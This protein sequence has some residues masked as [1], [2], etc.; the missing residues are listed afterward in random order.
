MAKEIRVIRFDWAIKN[1]LPVLIEPKDIFPE[2][3]LIE[4]EKF[5][6]IIES[7][8]DEWIYFLK[9]ETIRDDFKAKNID[10]A[11]GKLDI[12]KMDPKERKGYERYLMQLTD[13][14]DIIESAIEE[15]MENRR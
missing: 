7:D 15:G 10:K 1:I 11:K 8:L 13:E 3:Y 6:D 9:H 5:Q 14:K 4:V 12:L 2:H